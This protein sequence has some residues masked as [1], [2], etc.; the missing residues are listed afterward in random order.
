[1]SYLWE[2]PDWPRFTWNEGAV[3]ALLATARHRQGRLLGRMEGLGLAERDEASLQA[4]TQEAIKSSEIEGEHLRADLVRSSIARRLG[5]DAAGLAPADRTTDGL[6]DMVVDATKNYAAPL[7]AERLFGWHRSLFAGGHGPH[8]IAV[9][10]WRDDSKGPM[11]VVSGQLGAE[12][13]HYE[14]PPA[15]RLE[16]EMADFIAWENAPSPLDPVLKAAIAHLWFVTIHPFDDGNGRIARAIADRALAR[17]EESGRRF[18]SMSAQIREERRHYYD[19]L[20]LTQKDSLD[21]THWLKWFLECLGRAME[22]SEAT[23]ASILAKER[24]WKSVGD[25]P[26]NE[27]QRLMLNKLLDGFE[28]KLSTGKWA[29]IAKCSQD[30]AHRDIMDLIEKGILVQ[31]EA[32]GRSTSYSLRQVLS[33][34]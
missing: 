9:G 14:A 10:R 34:S 24:F 17:S 5:M 8:P 29:K 32:G 12:K 3:S 19:V 25:K 6:A 27:R 22:G 16:K 23:L 4:L 1:M 13:V 18:Y 33:S 21:I 28:G 20:E 31:D 26:L 15:G 2:L 7:T 30:T 11:Q